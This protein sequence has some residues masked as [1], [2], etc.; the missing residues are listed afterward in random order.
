MTV[1]RTVIADDEK[2]ARDELGFIL[3]SVDG[4]EMVGEADNGLDAYNLIERESPDLALL[5]VQMPGLDGFQLVREIRTLARSP[6]VIFVTAYDHYAIQAFEV[7]AL[8]YLLKP[9]A[10]DRLVQAVDRV[11]PLVEQQSPLDE[12]LTRLFENL[13]KRARHLNKI[14]VRRFKNLHLLD[15]HDVIYGYVRDGVVFIVTDA[16][17]DMV[18]YRT[19]DEFASDL[20][21]DV[22]HRVHRSYLANIDRIRQIIPQA[23]GNYELLMGDKNGTRIPLSRQHARELRRIYKW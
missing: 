19:L 22:F 15:V 8:D 7:S 1:I 4:V 20:D 21:P 13:P 18:S 3:R 6:L 12:T 2:P 9:V 16:H 14:P 17:E 5:D 23:S 10:R 11:R